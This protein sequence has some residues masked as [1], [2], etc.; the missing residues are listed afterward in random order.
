MRTVITIYDKTMCMAWQDNNTVLFMST[1]HSIASR[2]DSCM[3]ATEHCNNVPK[4]AEIW[5]DEEH[6]E[7][8]F[9]FSLL[10]NDYNMHIGKSN[11]CAQ[12]C[13]YYSLT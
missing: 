3:K 2:D 10:I 8:T 7:K 6:S 13:S 1:T 5:V 9:N 11:S 12:Q 4:D